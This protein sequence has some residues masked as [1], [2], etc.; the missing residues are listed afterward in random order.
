MKCGA[1]PAGCSPPQPSNMIK[2]LPSGVIVNDRVMSHPGQ[3][4]ATSPAI[5]PLA[6]EPY[7]C[8]PPKPSST[9]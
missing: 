5:T 6:A 4:A 9:M 1:V 7:L 8:S 3:L 2:P